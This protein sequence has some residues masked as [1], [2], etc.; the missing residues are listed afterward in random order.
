[1]ICG[2]LETFFLLLSFKILF[3]GNYKR[4]SRKKCFDFVMEEMRS[5]E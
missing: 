1:M 4:N 3:S 2:F 5:N